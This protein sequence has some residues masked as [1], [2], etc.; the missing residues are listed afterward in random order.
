MRWHISYNLAV[1]RLI[2]FGNAMEP[3]PAADPAPAGGGMGAD[4]EAQ[5]LASSTDSAKVCADAV[6]M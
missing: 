1:L 6:Q 4:A 5:R 2:S 3:D